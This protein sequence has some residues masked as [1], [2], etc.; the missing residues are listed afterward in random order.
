MYGLQIIEIYWN[1]L[2][3]IIMA[4][5][6]VVKVNNVIFNLFCKKKKKHFIKSDK[7][8]W[9]VYIPLGSHSTA[10]DL[11]GAPDSI[12]SEMYR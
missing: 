12:S 8:F 10:R 5:I 7:T 1:I 2:L 11:D 4:Q 6:F 3:T 9:I